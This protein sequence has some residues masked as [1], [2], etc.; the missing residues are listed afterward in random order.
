MLT[1]VRVPAAL[2]PAFEFA[3]AMVRR[4][5]ADIAHSPEKGTIHVA[6]ERYLFLRADSLYLGWYTALRDVFG[7]DAASGFI[8][9]TARAIGANDCNA[10]SEKLALHDGVARLASGPVHFAHAGWAFVDIFDDSAP[11]SDESYFL[12]YSHPNTFE[13]EV[14]RARTLASEDCACLFSA[15]YSAGWCSAAF[16]LELHA[17]EIRCL[18]RGDE[19]CEFI[20]APEVKLAEHQARLEA[21]RER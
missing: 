10:F 11:A 17:R 12:H 3:Q 20:M 14:L 15:G 18:A 8:Y 7:K 19:L 16:G 9:S 2:A 6:G 5:F 1:S 4:E 13:T 21:S